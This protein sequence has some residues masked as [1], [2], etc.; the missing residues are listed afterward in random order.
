MNRTQVIQNARSLRW[1]GLDPLVDPTKGVVTLLGEQFFNNIINALNSSDISDVTVFGA[2]GTGSAGDATGNVQAFQQAVNTVIQN[3]GG[4]L[5]IPGGTYVLNAPIVIP[6]SAPPIWFQGEGWCT[7][8]QL[9]GTLPTGQGILDISSSNFRA[10]DFVLDGNKL[11]STPLLYNSGFATA[12]GPNDPMA[13]SLTQGTSIWIHGPGENYL[14]ERIKF[15][16]AAG[17]SAIVDALT[18]SINSVEFAECWG[19]NNRPTTFGVTAGQAIYGSYN[20]GILAKGDGTGAS[21]G[22]VSG[23][24]VHDSLFERNVG[25]CIW[26]HNYGFQRFNSEFRYTDNR[27]LD[28]GLDGILVDIVSGGI[29]SGN[30]FRRIGYVCADDTSQSVPRWLV[31]LNATAIDSGIVKGVPYVGNSITSCNGGAID[32]DT[33][34]MSL[35]SENTCRVPYSDE[36]E[37]T[38]DQIAITGPTNSGNGSYGINLAVN[39]AVAEGG[40]FINIKGNTLLNLPAG[41]MRLYAARYCL[42][43]GNLIQAPTASIYA[44]IQMGPNGPNAYNRCY[45]NKICHN[46]INYAPASALPCV[47]EDD[48]LSGGNPMTSGESNAVFGNC[49]LQPAST[50]AIEFA[51]ASGSGSVVYSQQV[52]F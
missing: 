13:P 39:Y 18:G 2:R 50:S 35:I 8:L 7:V 44:P 42:V 52:W 10:S 40:S 34:C 15:M 33:H 24:F 20:G 48:S 32:L 5:Y 47:K 16:H 38:E 3:G 4:I 49:P 29:V 19:I 23:L 36:P 21:S 28:C 31:G 12:K 43:E 30:V 37:Y 26:S 27:F 9:T 51:K 14:F 6:A 45:G 22:V 25:N 1:N 41:A 17:Y 11:V 46:E